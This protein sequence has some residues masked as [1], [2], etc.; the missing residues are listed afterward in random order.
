MGRGHLAWEPLGPLEH[1]GCSTGQEGERRKDREP[2]VGAEP[3][4]G[5]GGRRT[6]VG[7]APS[8]DPKGLTCH[9]A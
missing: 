3:E 8:W 9:R 2:L 4:V 6:E 1:Q 7:K 5:L